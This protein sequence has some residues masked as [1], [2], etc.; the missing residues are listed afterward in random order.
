[1]A[2]QTGLKAAK[3]PH[4]R[5]EFVSFVALRMRAPALKETKDTYEQR[6]TVPF[7]A[8]SGSA[9]IDEVKEPERRLAQRNNVGKRLLPPTPF[10]TPDQVRDDDEAKMFLNTRPH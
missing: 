6:E 4:A 10:V 7:V 8:L 5:I 2:N 3:A 9:N 1:M